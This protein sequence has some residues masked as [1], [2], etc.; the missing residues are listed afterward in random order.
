MASAGPKISFLGLLISGP[1][2]INQLKSQFWYSELKRL[3]TLLMFRTNHEDIQRLCV[4]I[5]T[6]LT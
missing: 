6:E 1:L 2:E 5:K 3:W 4:T